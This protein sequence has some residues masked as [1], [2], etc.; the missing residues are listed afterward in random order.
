M[1]DISHE[2][3]PSHSG[4][5]GWAILGGFVLAWD[6]FARETLSSAVDRALE[7]P[8]GR[9]VAIGSVALT[10]AHLLNLLPERYDP[11]VQ[12][13]EALNR[14]RDNGSHQNPSL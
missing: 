6:V 8:V 14:I 4:T 1:G 11:F 12:T 9:Y 10:G 7:R 2:I 13:F 3:E 5:T